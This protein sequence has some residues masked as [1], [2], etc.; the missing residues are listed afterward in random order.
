MTSS[1]LGAALLRAKNYPGLTVIGGDINHVVDDLPIWQEFLA[2]GYSNLFTVCKRRW[3]LDVYPTCRDATFNDTL[4]LPSA[5]VTLLSG[6]KVHIDRKFDCHAPVTATFAV[7]TVG[8]L[9]SMWALPKTWDGVEIDMNAL[10]AAYDATISEV[11]FAE[12]VRLAPDKPND[13]YVRWC[14]KLEKAVGKVARV[15]DDDMPTI[16]APQGLPRAY[17][18]RG[19]KPK[20]VQKA[21][22][23]TARIT[24]APVFMPPSDDQPVL[25]RQRIKQVR[26]ISCLLSRVRKYEQQY[27]GLRD[28]VVIHEQQHCSRMQIMSEWHAVVQ[29]SG[30]HP[31]FMH[32]VSRP[33]RLGFEFV[34][35]PRADGLQLLLQWVTKDCNALAESIKAKRRRLLK[36]KIRI[37]Y[38]SATGAF[39]FKLL[40]PRA[41]PPLEC[42]HVKEYFQL[43]RLRMC[44]KGPALFRIEQHDKFNVS[45]PLEFGDK[46]CYLRPVMPPG[47]FQVIP[48]ADSPGLTEALE[49][50][51]KSAGEITVSQTTVVHDPNAVATHV[52]DF[53]SQYWKREDQDTGQFPS[54]EVASELLERVIPPMQGD[55]KA[56]TWRDLQ[57]ICKNMK[58]FAARGADGF[59]SYELQ[60]MP[61]R[62]WQHLFELLESFNDWPDSLVSCKTH[63]L[64]K[65]DVDVTPKDTRPITI[66]GI[67]YRLWAS[68]QAGVILSHWQRVLP[69]TISGGLPHRGTSDVIGIV[70]Q[71]IEMAE[72]HGKALSGFVL[73]VVKAFNAIDRRLAITAMTRMGLPMR[74]AAKWRSALRQL[75]RH[76]QINGNLSQGYD[77]S[78]GVPEG[79]CLS[80]LAMLSLTYGWHQLTSEVDA[81][82]LSYADN[83]EWFT[84]DFAVNELMLEQTLRY[85]HHM[86]LTLA[87]RKS[88]CWA[89]TEA[90]Q[91]QWGPL[92]TLF[93]PRQP[94]QYRDAACDLGIDI[95]YNKK[96]RHVQQPQRFATALEKTVKLQTLPAHVDTKEGLIRRSVLPTALFGCETMYPSKSAL[97]RLRTALS[98]AFLGYFRTANPWITCAIADCDPECHVLFHIFLKAAALVKMGGALASNFWQLVQQQTEFPS[99]IAGPSKV[100]AFACERLGWLICDDFVLMPSPGIR[101]S[102]LLADKVELKFHVTRSWSKILREHLTHK[103]QL[104]DLPDIDLIQSRAVYLDL[105]VADR[106]LVLYHM[107]GAIQTNLVRAKYKHG[108]TEKCTYCDGRD[109]V[110]HRHFDCSVTEQVREE[111]S[112][113][114]STFQALPVAQF[115]SALCLE[116]EDYGMALAANHMI[117]LE[118]TPPQTGESLLVYTDGRMEVTRGS[119]FPAAGY[120]V[121]SSTCTTAQARTEA[122]QEYLAN[123]TVPDFQIMCVGKVPGRQT[124]NRGELAAGILALSLS[125]DVELVSDSQYALDTIQ[126]V[127]DF[128]H[129]EF[130]SGA[131]NLDLIAVLVRLVSDTQHTRVVLRKVKSHQQLQSS[132]TP[133]EMFDI[134]GNMFADEV[135]K[136]CAQCR[137]GPM[138]ASKVTV[139]AAAREQWQVMT[140][141]LRFQ[142]VVAREFHKA[143]R[144][145]SQRESVEVRDDRISALEQWPSADVVFPTFPE[146]TDD[147]RKAC[148]FTSTYTVALLAWLTRVGWP[149]SDV[150]GDPGV[151]CLELY[152]SFQLFSGMTAPYNLA[153]KFGQQPHFDCIENNPSVGMLPRTRVQEL[154]IFERSLHFVSK[155]FGE[156]WVPWTLKKSVQTLNLLGNTSSSW[157]GFTRRQVFPRSDRVLQIINDRLKEGFVK[158][159]GIGLIQTP[160]DPPIETFQLQPEDRSRNHFTSYRHFRRLCA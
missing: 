16:S 98:R 111:W 67:P 76:F 53:W 58:P 59:A 43:S 159:F 137:Q 88:W 117:T 97:D 152:I 63:L 143:W 140:R 55:D 47:T 22:P 128:P 129:L 4:L 130:Y 82:R 144:E 104:Q 29:S 95:A 46:H 32:W 24:S 99:V 56:V 115:H 132:H 14:Q 19:K 69:P 11:E 102:L 62:A 145:A 51:T 108:Q 112:A 72:L 8:L 138:E 13:A 23:T 80:I 81:V 79:D 136:Q 126:Q 151:T 78:T 20:L 77:S 27:G 60:Q 33:E 100:F 15:T 87:P 113:S 21:A 116:H 37:D 9:R 139:D 73:D 85:L 42:V 5:M 74:V 3:P 94:V 105:P 110:R 123:D 148:Y 121:V 31:T 17:R 48:D 92:W 61:D 107:S 93:F 52:H 68:A 158:R 36:L 26:R 7:P 54:Y 1:L 103:V 90:L 141:L 127:L 45:L 91:E 156:R 101:I 135:A 154:L 89:T 134:L 44:T 70:T 34:Q 120:A 65:V 150:P 41:S 57:R 75:R 153:T 39:V 35:I 133:L 28:A 109:T 125:K 96:G 38:H 147:I 10:E 84:E 106:K 83:M 157:G 124:N 49:S 18:G 50:A 2:A 155:M 149:V 142:A 6:I 160:K 12:V 146:L 114:L 25:L 122:I 131:L 86:R 30:Y 64:P 66:A 71:S 119:L 40:R 118:V